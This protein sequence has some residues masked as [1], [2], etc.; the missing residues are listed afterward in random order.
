[1]QP[2]QVVGT[3]KKSRKKNR[4][5]HDLIFLR[6]SKYLRVTRET[7]FPQDKKDAKIGVTKPK[8]PFGILFAVS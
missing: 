3:Q 4:K 5:Q 2:P 6:G 7:I 1:M 8:K